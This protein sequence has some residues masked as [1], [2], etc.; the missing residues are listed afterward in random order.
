MRTSS[1]ASIAICVLADVLLVSLLADGFRTCFVS[2]VTVF[3]GVVSG[4]VLGQVHYYPARAGWEH[5]CQ[6]CCG[7][8]SVPEISEAV[9]DDS[10]RRRSTELDDDAW[11]G[12]EIHL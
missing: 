3:G 6:D 9:L 8:L 10:F 1:V 5:G 7:M 4:F 2:R 11:I 12:T